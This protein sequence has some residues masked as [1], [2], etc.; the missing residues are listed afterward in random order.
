MNSLSR[1]NPEIIDKIKTASNNSDL[2]FFIDTFTNY[3]KYSNG[4]NK[5]DF[6]NAVFVQAFF[7]CGKELLD[8]FLKSG[9]DVNEKD[10]FDNTALILSAFSGYEESVHFLLDN[11][12]DPEARAEDGRTSLYWA[13]ANNMHSVLARLFEEFDVSVYDSDMSFNTPFSELIRHNDVIS[14]EYYIS[15]I[16]IENLDSYFKW[17]S[18]SYAILK[19]NN[20]L[21]STFNKAV[22][23]IKSRK[24]TAET[25]IEP[26]KNNGNENIAVFDR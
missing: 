25:L 6:I 23:N 15:R 16:G 5:T 12:A 14:M 7:H 26:I 3:E 11:G 8:L 22:S 19:G 18:K 17:D 1:L 4:M 10:S 13:C 21:W 20:D 2:D 24:R 9:V